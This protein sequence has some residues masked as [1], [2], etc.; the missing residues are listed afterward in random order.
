MAFQAVEQVKKAEAEAAAVI[1]KAEQ[2]AKDIIARAHDDGEALLNRMQT[3]SGAEAKN[4]IH[5]AQTE[6]DKVREKAKIPTQE[7]LEALNR[8]TSQKQA[9]VIQ[10][11]I[12]RIF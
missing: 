9:D 3:E 4:I 7:A 11:V 8:E 5:Y 2:D 1:A 6:A 10:K 12:D